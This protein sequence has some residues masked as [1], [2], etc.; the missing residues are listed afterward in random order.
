[1]HVV[2]A[3]SIRAV[4]RL[5]RGNV[6]WDGIGGGKASKSQ[7]Q[8]FGPRDW[9]ADPKE[10]KFMQSSEGGGAKVCRQRNRAQRGAAGPGALRHADAKSRVVKEGVSSPTRATS[11]VMR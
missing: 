7:L 8:Q 10:V 2:K 6:E 4:A 9:P 3:R 11:P 1:M 5:R